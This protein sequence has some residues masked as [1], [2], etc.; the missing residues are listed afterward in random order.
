MQALGER[1]N[2]YLAA[3]IQPDG[4]KTAPSKEEVKEALQAKLPAYSVPNV[5]VF[6]DQFPVKA[7]CLN[8]QISTQ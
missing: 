7:M 1:D 4:F 3:W 6:I 2:R 5:F 8:H